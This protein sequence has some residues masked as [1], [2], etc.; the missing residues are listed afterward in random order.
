[1][2]GHWD[3]RSQ[4]QAIDRFLAAGQEVAQATSDSRQKH[5][6]DFGTVD[7][8]DPSVR[9]E[10]SPSDTQPAIPTHGPVQAGP[11]ST[12]GKDLLNERPHGAKSPKPPDRMS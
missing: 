11:R 1:M 5:V 4:Y 3:H 9:F 2:K 12:Y 6:I 8:S 7:L 10:T